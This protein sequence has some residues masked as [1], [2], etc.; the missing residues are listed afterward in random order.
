MKELLFEIINE[1]Q[2]GKVIIDSES[3][4]IC[5]NTLL[6]EGNNYQSFIQNH[7]FPVLFIENLEE[8]I[9]LL[10]KYLNLELTISRRQ[11]LIINNQELNLK[12]FLITYLFVNATTDDFLNPCAMLRN[13]IAFL[14]NQTLTNLN[15]SVP[16][17]YL[18][19]SYIQISDTL[20][21]VYMETPHKIEISI[22]NGTDTYHLPSISYGISNNTCYI[23]SVLNPKQAANT[24]YQKQIKRLLYKIN[25]SVSEEYLNVSPSAVLSLSIFLRILKLHHIKNVKVITYLPLRYLS[26]D[27]TA[28]E[29]K[30]F[31]E[32]NDFIQTN[33]T[34]KL[35]DTF[36]RLQYHGIINI[37]SYPYENDDSLHVT[38]NMHLP[39]NN[40]FLSNINK[41]TLN[42]K[43][44]QLVY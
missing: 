36:I 44:H 38:I 21:S 42:K 15:Y 13:K 9:S 28:Q 27:L 4:P 10:E 29:R 34:N 20:D 35:I 43:D 3:W 2:A 32:R 39:D 5:F 12:K 6:K 19:N 26:R 40:S 24:S 7:N 11:P 33:A 37:T 22:T 17:N 1:A 14:Q 31:I 25:E 30:E 16:F 8:F 41:K 23:Y 18:P